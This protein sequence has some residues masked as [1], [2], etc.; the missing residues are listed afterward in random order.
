MVTWD[1][2]AIVDRL[3]IP[4]PEPFR[5]FQPVRSVHPN[6]RFPIKAIPD[7]FG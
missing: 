4:R 7:Q 3:V 6:I 2:V 1:P 5:L